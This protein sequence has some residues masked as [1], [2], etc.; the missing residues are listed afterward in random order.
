MIKINFSLE[1]ETADLEIVE[2]IHAE[3]MKRNVNIPEN[4]N[5][6]P[7]SNSE[8]ID[9]IMEAFVDSNSSLDITEFNELKKRVSDILWK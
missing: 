1:M 8:I 6:N 7:S 9:G 2:R 4:I 5:I 3:E